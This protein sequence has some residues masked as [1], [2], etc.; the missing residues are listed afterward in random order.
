MPL[1]QAW[2][3]E[4]KFPEDWKRPENPNTLVQL[5]GLTWHFSQDVEAAKKKLV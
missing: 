5:A 2:F 4:N 3:G 1:S